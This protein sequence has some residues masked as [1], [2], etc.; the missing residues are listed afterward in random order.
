MSD[1]IEELE[2]QLGA[3]Y[4]R[5]REL[6]K[7]SLLDELTGLGNRRGLN[8]HLGRAVAQA[9]RQHTDLAFVAIDI[10]H[11]KL[12]NDTHG[13]DV[14]DKVLQRVGRILQSAIRAGDYAFRQGGEEFSVIAFTSRGAVL[15][16]EKLRQAIEDGHQSNEVPVTISLGVSMAR[17]GDTAERL[18]K[19]ADEALYRAKESGRNRVEIG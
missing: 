5:I 11:F 19:R 18:T 2:F 7:L 13:H 12:V 14:G 4:A 10:D 9:D 15:L 3:A 8:A 6:E 16:A 1:R 17:I